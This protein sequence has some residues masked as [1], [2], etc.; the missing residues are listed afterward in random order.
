MYRRQAINWFSQRVGL[1]NSY[2]NYLAICRYFS[3]I[4][5]FSVVDNM[6][7][8]L[9]FYFACKNYFHRKKCSTVIKLLKYFIHDWKSLLFGKSNGKSL[10]NCNS[11]C[12]GQPSGWIS[13]LLASCTVCTYWDPK[14]RQLDKK[15]SSP[16]IALLYSVWYSARIWAPNIKNFFF[17]QC[18]H[19]DRHRLSHLN[20]RYE[21]YIDRHLIYRHIVNCCINC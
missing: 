6:H 5:T 3:K 8:L 12:R 11:N 16:I 18:R 2:Y 4:K 1:G 19:R 15:R 14:L 13:W 21:P 17:W 9:C 10:S 7:F 20:N